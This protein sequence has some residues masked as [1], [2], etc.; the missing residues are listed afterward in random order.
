MR[1]SG[2]RAVAIRAAGLSDTALEAVKALIDN[3]RRLEGL[4]DA[5][6][7]GTASATGSRRTSG[8][9]RKPA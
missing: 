9:G 7:P 5:E 3:A 1:D 4:D 6:E 2:V 8:R